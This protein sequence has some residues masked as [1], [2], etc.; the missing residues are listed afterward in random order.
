MG[1]LVRISIYAL[2]ILILYFWVTAIVR[3]YQNK[4]V[5]EENIQIA[6][7]L[8][9]DSM[10][11]DLTN[12]FADDTSAL[13]SDGDVVD[14]KIDYESLDKKSRKWKKNQFL[15]HRLQKESNKYHWK[16]LDINKNLQLS[17]TKQNL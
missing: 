3:S 1:R 9:L 17:P 2:I 5:E 15:R 13:I 14:G 12:I 7:T 6:D 11:V 4:S 10:S 16:N 8:S